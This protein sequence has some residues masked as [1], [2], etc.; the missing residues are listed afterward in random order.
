M[1]LTRAYLES[2]VVH[3][4]GPWLEAVGL[5]VANVDG[6]NAD[7]NDVI[8]TALA[9]LGYTVAD[10]ADVND[11]DLAAV[12]AAQEYRVRLI[13]Q[14]HVLFLVRRRFM[15]VDYSAGNRS[16]S[17]GQLWPRLEAM[18]GDLREEVAAQGGMPVAYA[19]AAAGKM[20]GGKDRGAG[21]LRWPCP[22]EAYDPCGDP[23]RLP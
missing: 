22:A 6:T 20:T 1:P 21:G 3:A 15:A 9:S 12:P 8:Y 17:L 16:R 11:A 23:G 14:L 4:F 2:T 18:I 10:P 13:V 7:L 19:M 5:D